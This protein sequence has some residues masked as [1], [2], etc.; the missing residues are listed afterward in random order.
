MPASRGYNTSA[1]VSE[2]PGAF[3]IIG[4]NDFTNGAQDTLPSIAANSTFDYF[5]KIDNAGSQWKV[6]KTV[7]YMRHD[8]PT[9]TTGIVF[10]GMDCIS[11]LYPGTSTVVAINTYVVLNGW[12]FKATTGGTTAVKFIGFPN[13]NT[14]KGATTTDGTVVWTSFGKAVLV[15][16]RYANVSVSPATPV[17]AIIALFQS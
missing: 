2:A 14:V 13:F 6:Q 10:G 8:G 7:N 16:I 11:P 1:R 5:L 12:L 9:E 3:A 17:A 15:R 4:A